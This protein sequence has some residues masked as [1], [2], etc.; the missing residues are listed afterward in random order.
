MYNKI[1]S[2]NSLDHVLVVEVDHDLDVVRIF[3]FFL[4]TSLEISYSGGD[5]RR[6]S[7]GYA[8]D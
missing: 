2:W 4:R 5:R 6:R 8:Y 3:S 7:P 1:Y